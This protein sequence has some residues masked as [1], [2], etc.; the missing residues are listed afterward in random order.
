MSWLYYA[1]RL[2]EFPSAL[3]GVALGTVLL[4]SLVRHHQA[5][6]T[7]AYSHLL[8][9]GLRLTL[10]L[11]APRRGRARDACRCR[12]SPPS[13]GTATCS[14][15]HD[16]MM[17]RSALIAYAAGLGGII[18][19]KIL[20]P[21]L[22]RAPEHPHAG[23]GRRSPRSAVTQL[24]NAALVPVLGARR[25]RAGDLPRGVLQ[26]R[27]A[28]VAHRTARAPTTPSPGWAAF[29]LKLAVALYLMG[30]ALWFTMGSETSWFEIPAS[31]RAAKLALVIVAGTVAYF[32]ALCADG[33]AA[34]RLHAPRVGDAMRI[35]RHP[36]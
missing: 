35:V 16:V 34:A 15:R 7:Q 13:S 27:L 6:D 24:L 18:L 32:A 36:Q 2:M 22:L 11:A 17:T 19:V 29:L 26:R 14:P 30:G 31:A 20:A 5:A 23:E 1:D 21:G 25:T 28:L 12:S 9:W 4:P 8:D 3:L 10:L 33:P